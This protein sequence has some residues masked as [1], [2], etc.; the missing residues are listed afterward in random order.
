[1]NCTDD[2]RT[3]PFR[4]HW[5]AINS[6]LLPLRITVG[7]P[8]NYSLGRSQETHLDV[9]ASEREIPNLPSAQVNQQRAEPFPSLDLTS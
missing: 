2:N 8:S 9:P 5:V 3:R 1:M 4:P 6:A 7:A